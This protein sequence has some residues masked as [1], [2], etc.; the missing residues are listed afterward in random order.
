M[1][2]P[3]KMLPKDLSRTESLDRRL[4]P[5]AVSDQEFRNS[6][7]VCTVSW[8][9]RCIWT[10]EAVPTPGVSSLLLQGSVLK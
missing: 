6:S 1:Q 8:D 10:P 5:H 4:E 9:L 7:V 3:Y 2:A